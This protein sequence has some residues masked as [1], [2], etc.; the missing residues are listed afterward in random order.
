MEILLL[1]KY[2]PLR[3]SRGLMFLKSLIQNYQLQLPIW[4]TFLTQQIQLGTYEKTTLGT[5]TISH[6][7]GKAS[8]ACLRRIWKKPQENTQCLL[9]R[10]R[11][12]DTKQR[13]IAS[14]GILQEET[15]Q[16]RIQDRQIYLYYIPELMF[17]KEVWYNGMEKGC[18]VKVCSLQR[19]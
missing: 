13:I 6:S 8:R 10:V 16:C 11:S 17:V 4:R 18:L 12:L 15:L 1:F 2:F 9:L 7:S 14:T 5:L 19:D 3:F